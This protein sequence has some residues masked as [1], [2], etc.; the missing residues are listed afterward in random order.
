M[1]TGHRT[2]PISIRGPGA[3]TECVEKDTPLLERMGPGFIF[4]GGRSCQIE[5]ELNERHG[6]MEYP[7]CERAPAAYRDPE[8]QA[9]TVILRRKA[10]GITMVA[11]GRD[12]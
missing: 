2:A 9:V 12:A 8:C 5:G 4:R 3:D 1:P 10:V 7:S 11:L 6:V